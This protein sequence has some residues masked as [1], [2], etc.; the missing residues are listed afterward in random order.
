MNDIE[1]KEIAKQISEKIYRCDELTQNIIID[2][3]NHKRG[4]WYKIPSVILAN[5]ICD[6]LSISRS[7]YYKRISLILEKHSTK[8]KRQIG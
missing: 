5:E 7:K 8:L 6:K 1:H 3:L 2:V 4:E